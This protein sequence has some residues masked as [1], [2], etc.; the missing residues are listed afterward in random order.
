MS[1]TRRRTNNHFCGWGPGTTWVRLTKVG[2]G[3]MCYDESWWPWTYNELSITARKNNNGWLTS[4]SIWELHPFMVSCRCRFSWRTLA[5]VLNEH[6]SHQHCQWRPVSLK[7]V[8]WG[9]LVILKPL[10]PSVLSLFISQSHFSDYLSSVMTLGI[11]MI[12][13]YRSVDLPDF[14]SDQESPER[15]RKQ[16][17]F[18]VE[19]ISSRRLLF[20]L[21]TFK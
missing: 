10:C 2:M 12:Q 8:T 15:K 13:L 4:A 20:C 3:V 5:Y 7:T 6:K 14:P 19:K 18:S 16:I 11:K 17:E 9:I 21:I 1:D